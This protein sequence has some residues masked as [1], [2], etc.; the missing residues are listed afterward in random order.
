MRSKKNCACPKPRIGKA[1][2]ASR[3]ISK[4]LI[5]RLKGVELRRILT[6][7]GKSRLKNEADH[8]MGFAGLCSRRFGACAGARDDHP[9]ATVRLLASCENKRRYPGVSIRGRTRR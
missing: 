9:G 1:K 4:R 2:T 3:I 5:V 6:N 8:F 7:A